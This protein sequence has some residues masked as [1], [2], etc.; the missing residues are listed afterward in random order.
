[1]E[2]ANITKLNIEKGKDLFASGTRAV[3]LNCHSSNN[4]DWS[5]IKAGGVKSTPPPK[6]IETQTHT[7]KIYIFCSV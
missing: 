4:P 1:M 5:H 7:M 2:K 3:Q 6:R